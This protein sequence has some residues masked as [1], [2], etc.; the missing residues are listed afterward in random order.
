IRL[1]EDALDAGEGSALADQAM[2]QALL[3]LAHARVGASG[4]AA[5]ALAAVDE[6]TGNRAQGTVAD[7]RLR[8]EVART[9]ALTHLDGTEAG[10]A[11]RSLR[12]W[13]RDRDR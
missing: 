9:A 8:A 2:A 4:A 3:A 11:L 7:A 1:L 12:R 6:E 5:A 10:S 13:A